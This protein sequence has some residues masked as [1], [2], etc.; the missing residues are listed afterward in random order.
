MDWNETFANYK[1]CKFEDIAAYVEQEK[2]EYMKTL[3][4]QVE[5]ATSYLVIKKAFYEK[6][7]KQ[8]IPVAKN[9]KKN[10]MAN[11]LSEHKK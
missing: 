4:K 7:F 11:W 3:T 1:K 9:Q 2:P 5:A 6:Y 8:Y 10:V